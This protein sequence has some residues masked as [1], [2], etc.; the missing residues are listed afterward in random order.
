MTDNLDHI[1]KLAEPR[2]ILEFGCW[3]AGWSGYVEKTSIVNMDECG[4]ALTIG[5]IVEPLLPDL[6]IFV[7]ANL[8]AEEVVTRIALFGEWLSAMITEQR[9]SKN[10]EERS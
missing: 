10:T 1:M 8:P 5:M 3:P 4:R 2:R 6:K 7:D 9:Y